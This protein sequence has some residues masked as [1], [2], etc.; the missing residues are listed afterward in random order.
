[1]SEKVQTKNRVDRVHYL[2]RT[3]EDHA[4]PLIRLINMYYPV[5]QYV[6]K[7][8]RRGLDVGCGW[9]WAIKYFRDLGVEMHGFD[10]MRSILKDAISF[11]GKEKCVKH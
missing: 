11:C 1:M 7:N 3:Y 2:D 8:C 4:L 6:K 5:G 10:I 9:S